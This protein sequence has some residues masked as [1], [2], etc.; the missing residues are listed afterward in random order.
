ML[1]PLLVGGC[2]FSSILDS[3]PGTTGQPFPASYKAELLAFFRSYLSDP[4]AVRDAEMADPVLRPI[5]GQSRYISCL[6]FNPHESDGSYR[7][8]RT[9]A[10]L[11][12]NGRLDRV[13]DE[14]GDLCAGASYARF[15]ELEKLS[16]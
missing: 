14:L 12:N 1:L 7:G 15:P 13:L 11:Y 5:A 3:D 10:V 2:G 9:R 16:R 4:V 6:R 8:V